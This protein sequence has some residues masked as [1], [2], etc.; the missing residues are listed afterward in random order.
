MRPCTQH[1]WRRVGMRRPDVLTPVYTVRR[2]RAG[3]RRERSPH[4]RG[5]RQR[6]QTRAHSRTRLPVYDP[7][8]DPRP[9]REAGLS[10]SIVRGKCHRATGR[11]LTFWGL[12][13]VGE[14][15]Y[16][17]RSPGG[18]PRVPVTLRGHQ[19]TTPLVLRIRDSHRP[20]GRACS[21]ALEG[22]PAHS[23][24]SMLWRAVGVH[25]SMIH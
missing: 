11:V 20:K 9:Y 1:V 7:P 15:G 2:A 23:P 19:R 16:A 18:Y 8:A 12:T 24:G 3:R 4:R 21:P 25:V 13:D 6:R 14:I 10:L 17:L 22:A 5:S